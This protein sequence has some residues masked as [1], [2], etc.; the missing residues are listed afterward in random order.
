MKY[1]PSP[2]S[3]FCLKNKTTF[4]SGYVAKAEELKGKGVKEIVC[5]SVNDPF[6][7]AAWGEN[8]VSIIY[9]NIRKDSSPEV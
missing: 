4:F 2:F 5:V 3:C 7:M 9:L 1:R 6:V 8:Q